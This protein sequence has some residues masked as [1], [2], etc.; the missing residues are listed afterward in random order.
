MSR[1]ATPTLSGV[2]ATMASPPQDGD[3]QAVQ[4]VQVNR[5]CSARESIWCHM[6]VGSETKERRIARTAWTAWT[7]GT[8]LRLPLTKA[9]KPQTVVQRGLARLIEDSKRSTNFVRLVPKHR[10]TLRSSTRSSLRSPDSYLLTKDC[11]L[12]SRPAKPTCVRFA[13]ALTCRRSAWSLTCSAL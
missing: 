11:G 8:H 13:S 7:F 4:A 1:S 9:E 5:H 2:E 10:H 12:P 6:M 3:V